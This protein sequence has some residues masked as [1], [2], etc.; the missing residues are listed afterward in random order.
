MHW[1]VG[2]HGLC[3]RREATIRSRQSG[4][5]HQTSPRFYSQVT[6]QIPLL[7]FVHC[8]ELEPVMTLNA[9][10]AQTLLLQASVF[11]HLPGMT[12]PT[13]RL[14]LLIH[15]LPPPIL[16]LLDHVCRLHV[17]CSHY[18]TF[19]PQVL[20]HSGGAAPPLHLSPTRL[21]HLLLLLLRVSCRETRLGGG[22][23]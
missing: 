10:L 18:R 21:F 7:T 11:L 16:H 4:R 8:C 17:L 9:T 13:H 1:H 22:G 19:C 12:T 14:L 23:D 2:G 20:L 15:L 5:I 6:N 3:S